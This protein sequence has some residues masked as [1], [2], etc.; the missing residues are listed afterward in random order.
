MSAENDLRNLAL[1]R[2]ALTQYIK[3][4]CYQAGYL[5]RESVAQ[6][7]RYG[8]GNV[9]IM[10]AE[11]DKFIITCSCAA[12]KCCKCSKDKVRCIAIC[13]CGR[14]CTN[15][16]LLGCRFYLP[17]FLMTG[18]VTKLF[19]FHLLIT[20]ALAYPFFFHYIC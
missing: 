1:D 9:R 8:V 12:Q 13:G 15:N 3:R 16:K 2:Q 20:S 19:C 11:F 18:F 7:R 5:W 17:L 4:A 10:G 14:K 6:S